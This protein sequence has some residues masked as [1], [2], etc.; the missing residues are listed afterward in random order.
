MNPQSWKQVILLGSHFPVK[1]L[2]IFGNSFRKRRA[3]VSVPSHSTCTIIF[4]PIVTVLEVQYSIFTVI[5]LLSGLSEYL[6]KGFP[7]KQ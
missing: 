1:G 4:L 2:T 6:E 3:S 7:F 5:A